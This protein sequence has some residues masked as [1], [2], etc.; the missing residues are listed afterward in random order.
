MRNAPSVL[1]QRSRPS[2]APLMAPPAAEPV[3]CAVADEHAIT[4]AKALAKSSTAH[5]PD[6]LVS[7]FAPLMIH[8]L[9]K[10]IT[11]HRLNKTSYAGTKITFSASVAG[12]EDLRFKQRGSPTGKQ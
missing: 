11:L 12:E 10:K 4:R 5:L 9:F 6:V 7:E 1:S 2:F 8:L 3:G